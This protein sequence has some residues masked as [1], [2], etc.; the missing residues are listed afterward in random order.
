MYFWCIHN[1]G[2]SEKVFFA[3]FASVILMLCACS[4]EKTAEATCGR[5]SMNTVPVQSLVKYTKAFNLICNHNDLSYQFNYT[6][7]YKYFL[8]GKTQDEFWTM[9]IVISEKTGSRRM[10]DSVHHKLDFIHWSGFPDCNNCL[11]YI[12]GKNS[13]RIVMDNDFGELVIADF[14]FDGRE[15][16][17]VFN[18][19]GGNGGPMYTFFVQNENRKFSRD[20][21][22][23]DTMKYFPDDMDNNKKQLTTVVHANACE[24]CKTTYH[25]D[26]VS[27]KWIEVETEMIKP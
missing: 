18:D 3:L 6:L 23:S 13:K 17:A 2:M 15:D 1:K 25:L 27:G 9:D 22:L 11:S 20:P 26:T 7:E 21:F 8:Q 5:I 24:F 12:T 4:N 19:V 16:F 14:N 10:V